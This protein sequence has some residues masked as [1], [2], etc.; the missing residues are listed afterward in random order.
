[1]SPSVISPIVFLPPFRR[2]H[3][4]V[5]LP[6]PAVA[7]PPRPRSELLV[8]PPPDAELANL[9]ALRR[10]CAAWLNGLNADALAH[11]GDRV[12][13]Y[14]ALLCSGIQ[15]APLG[16]EEDSEEGKLLEVLRNPREWI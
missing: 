4:I 12:A 16:T 9:R 11:P 5:S 1:M 13:K 2:P 10:A 7:A 3:P 8:T 14:A 15:Y 6:P